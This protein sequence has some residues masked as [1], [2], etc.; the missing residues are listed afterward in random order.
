MTA[1]YLTMA[2]QPACNTST[3]DN[4][5]IDTGS[6]QPDPARTLKGNSSKAGDGDHH[7]DMLQY[8]IN[9]SRHHLTAAYQLILWAVARRS[10]RYLELH[11]M[12]TSMQINCS[13]AVLRPFRPTTHFTAYLLA[14][15]NDK[16]LYAIGS[17][18]EQP[19]MSMDHLPV[20]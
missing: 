13:A 4:L 12:C 17:R 18:K 11:E 9:N 6:R 8:W 20:A 5:C 19:P 1:R 7:P 14:F 15:Q 10:M 2:G 3:H 16:R